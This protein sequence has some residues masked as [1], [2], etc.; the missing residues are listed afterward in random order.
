MGTRSDE[1]KADD[2]NRDHQRHSL[3]VRPNSDL[4]LACDGVTTELY[5]RKWWGKRRLGIANIKD[6]SLGGIGFISSV[7]LQPNS[8]LKLAIEQKDMEIEIMRC[9]M[10]NNKLWFYGAKWLIPDDPWV[11]KFISSMRQRQAHN[12][13]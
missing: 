7:Q 3:R 4:A 12:G 11:V 6:I 5:Q 2:D 10:I 1:I 9:L 8:K 13:Q